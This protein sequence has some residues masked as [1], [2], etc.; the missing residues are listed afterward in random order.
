MSF[1]RGWLLWSIVPIWGYI[2]FLYLFRRQTRLT[3][4][5]TLRFF[6]DME[7]KTASIFRRKKPP[8]LLQLLLNL[9]IT[10][11]LIVSL[12]LP[13]IQA[14]RVPHLILVVDNS[15]S[16][17]ATDL[18]P[19]RL[20]FLVNE[21]R[22]LVRKY[23]SSRYSLI[24]GEPPYPKLLEARNAS[25]LIAKLEEV[26]PTAKRFMWREALSLAKS[27]GGEG[28]LIHLL[29]DGSVL[30]AIQEDN[31]YLNYFR[32][33]SLSGL[34]L[35]TQNNN[36]Y[37][38]RMVIEEIGGEYFLF[39][40]LKNDGESEVNLRLLVSYQEPLFQT[41]ITL[42]AREEREIL[43]KLTANYPFLKAE[44]KILSGLDFLD[45]DNQT[46]F[47]GGREEPLKVAM[48]GREN[49]FLQAALSAVKDEALLF[50]LKPEDMVFGDY[51]AYFLVDTRLSTL[52]SRPVVL[53]N[54]VGEDNKEISLTG[55]NW[56]GSEYVI[57]EH[58]LLRYV[59]LENLV[60]DK[61]FQGDYQGEALLSLRQGETE[62][63]LLIMENEPA[64]R[65]TFAFPLSFSN[66]PLLPAFPILIKNIIS[67]IDS[68]NIEAYLGEEISLT[69]GEIT[70]PSGNTDFLPEG[71]LR[72]VET[73]IY[74]V[75]TAFSS[76]F[77]S[78]N[79][80]PEE[81]SIQATLTYLSLPEPAKSIPLSLVPYV[82][83]LGILLLSLSYFLLWRR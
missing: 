72:L 43:Y 60:I 76:Y 49:L 38:K 79:Y 74:E 65:L 50:N 52:P 5:P 31:K 40:V 4:Y 16:L 11:L 62:I 53:L 44:F 71:R 73:G 12:S 80:P 69:E 41:E 25:M 34:P 55:D 68:K 83:L 14:Y 20:S 58:P 45:M 64:L 70:T 2:L 29:T 33:V 18:E 81:S 51:D 63:P 21:A 6:K 48:V 27:V 30:P 78:V 39:L 17:K 56:E 57:R 9:L 24:V 7:P 13:Y 66:L 23:P 61:A 26:K 10:A 22:E 47:S 67:Y 3:Y 46:F 59:D 1:E 8:F 42:T 15:F 82:I 75:K 36:V 54:Q 32:G 19:N 77:I 28:A 35:L 37:F